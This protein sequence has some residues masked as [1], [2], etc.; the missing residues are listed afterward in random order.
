[1]QFD[2]ATTRPDGDSRN[3]SRR[4]CRDEIGGQSPY[5]ERSSQPQYGL[6][7]RPSTLAPDGRRVGHAGS[8][9]PLISKGFRLARWV[10][11]EPDQCE[12]TWSQSWLA[13]EGSRQ[14]A[15]RHLWHFTSPDLHASILAGR[16]GA[17]P[18]SRTGRHRQATRF[19]RPMRGR[20]RRPRAGRPT[21]SPP[22][23]TVFSS[24]G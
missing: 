23:P 12:P 22:L 15:G 18:E 6:R 9:N 14:P 19:L 3:G 16:Q 5:P 20:M 24:P 10:D 11:Q 7:R 4:I 17:F 13:A 21:Q 2:R 8:R 1:M